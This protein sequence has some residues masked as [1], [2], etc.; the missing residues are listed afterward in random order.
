MQSVFLKILQDPTSQNLRQLSAQVFRAF[1]IKE[2][3]NSGNWPSPLIP[4]KAGFPFEGV[5]QIEGDGRSEP[6][7]WWFGFENGQT[8]SGPNCASQGENLAQLFC[9]PT[10]SK[11]VLLHYF[12]SHNLF[13]RPTPLL[14]IYFVISK[15]MEIY[16]PFSCLCFYLPNKICYLF[17]IFFF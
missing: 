17:R 8:C 5:E 13:P 14:S 10:C 2:I 3:L 11:W 12:L 1:L 6:R 4:S 15:N 16:L 9:F 7:N